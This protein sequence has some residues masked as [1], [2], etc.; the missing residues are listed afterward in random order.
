MH[1]HPHISQDP[2]LQAYEL[3]NV[4]MPPKSEV[5]EVKKDLSVGSGQGS[6]PIF[7]DM[8]KTE[9]ENSCTMKPDP[10]PI[11][12]SEVAGHAKADNSQVDGTDQTVK[13]EA[14]AL[15][16]DHASGTKSGKP[17]IKGV[18][19]TELFTPEQI[20]EH[21]TGLRQWVGQVSL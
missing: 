3:T 18:S 13:Q 10:E 17:K 16:A 21:I 14:N 15:P 2:Q 7:N 9:P 4:C 12:T 5:T 11:S 8:M 20:R 6:L 1:S 19:L